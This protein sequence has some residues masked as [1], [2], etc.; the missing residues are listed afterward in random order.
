IAQQLENTT[1]TLAKEYVELHGQIN[2]DP[3]KVFNELNPNYGAAYQKQF[4]V[5]YEKTSNE[6][7]VALDA[8]KQKAKT[9][10]G[11][12]GKK[13]AWQGK[14]DLDIKTHPRVKKELSQL[15]TNVTA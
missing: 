10:G 8:L 14:T 15:N 11:A 3:Q 12:C 6:I 5:I 9:L 2:P 4:L 13:L 7:L 1:K